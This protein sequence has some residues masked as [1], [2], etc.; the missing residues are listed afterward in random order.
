MS[1]FPA[2]PARIKGAPEKKIDII[3]IYSL[4]SEYVQV[5]FFF[6]LRYPLLAFKHLPRLQT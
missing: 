3:N 4:N 5:S 1:T 6:D 2:T